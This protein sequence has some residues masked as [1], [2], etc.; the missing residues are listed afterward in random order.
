MGL[1]N[2]FSLYSSSRNAGRYISHDK[3]QVF[4]GACQANCG[5]DLRFQWKLHQC[6]SE[7][8]TCDQEILPTQLESM[9]KN[10]GSNNSLYYH[11]K[12][13][14]Y[15]MSQ[16][17]LIVFRAYRDERT[18]GEVSFRFLVNSNPSG[19]KKNLFKKYNFQNPETI[20]K[21]AFS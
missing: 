16:W 15:N 13:S 17:Y 2:Y 10:A 21:F 20:H 14:V 3:E 12:S 18:F 4:I 8:S 11:T 9:L 1:S 6:A 5:G 7:N 19:G